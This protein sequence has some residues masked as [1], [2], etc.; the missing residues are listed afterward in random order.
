MEPEQIF[1]KQETLHVPAWAIG[2][3]QSN[4]GYSFE[5]TS[6][7]I[8]DVT[9]TL[10]MTNPVVPVKFLNFESYIP[11]EFIGV[12]TNIALI[13]CREKVFDDGLI[14]EYTF[15]GEVSYIMDG[16]KY[17]QGNDYKVRF[18]GG[19]IFVNNRPGMRIL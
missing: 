19:E 9:P 6:T 14:Q 18:E 5:I 15:R 7:G 13:R 2:K 1:N 8:I 4:R 11:E 3:F 12:V 17:S 16:R 10:L